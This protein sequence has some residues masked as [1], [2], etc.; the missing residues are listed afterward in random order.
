MK[1]ADQDQAAQQ[2]ARRYNRNAATAEMQHYGSIL[3]AA[4]VFFKEGTTGY[5]VMTTLEKVYSAPPARQHDQGDGDGQGRHRSSVA[6]SMARAANAAAGAAKIFASSALRLPRR[7][8]DGRGARRARPERPARRRHGPSIPTAEDVQKSAGH[9]HRARRQLAPRATASP[10]A[11]RWSRRTPTR[12]WNIQLRDGAL[13]ARDRD[14]YRRLSALIAR[15]MGVPGG[16]FD[17]SGLGLGKAI[18]RRCS[19]ARR[20]PVR[21]DRADRRRFAAVRRTSR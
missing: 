11:S 17:T 19:A 20:L 21:P 5:K 4:K 18:D 10:R 16:G 3:S 8:G 7:R 15:Q 9:R 2:R 12:I 6:N 1:A 13:A 14:Q